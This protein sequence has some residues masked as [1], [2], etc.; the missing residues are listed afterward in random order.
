MG[1]HE[2]D[3]H[4]TREGRQPDLKINSVQSRHSHVKNQALGI[5]QVIRME[6]PLSRCVFRRSVSRRSYQTADGLADRLV[7][8]HDAY[9]VTHSL[10]RYMLCVQS[11]RLTDLN[12][13]ASIIHHTTLDRIREPR[14]SHE[15]IGTVLLAS[16]F[17]QFACHLNE[18]RHRSSLHF[19][20]AL[21]S[22]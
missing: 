17:F 5:M 15:S 9:Q 13:N 3:W 10:R 8:V 20:H 19:V 16:R 6:E 12:S 11:I 7:V 4:R 22:L 18:L 14:P 1:R 21:S 2:D